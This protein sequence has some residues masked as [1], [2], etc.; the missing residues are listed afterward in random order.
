MMRMAT[1]ALVVLLSGLAISSVAYAEG[2]KP[3]KEAMVE[4]LEELDRR[5][6]SA[7]DFKALL[8][9]E[10]KEKGKNDL[11]YETVVY[12]RDKA[13]KLVILFLKPK[14]EA[15][16]GYL[17]IDKN[18]FMYDPNVGKW[19][20]RTERERIG[21]TTSQRADFD[22]SR[23][24]D[25]FAPSYEG[26]EKLGKLDV[27]HLQLEAKEDADVPYPIV[28]IWIDKKTGNL[29]KRQDHALS[30]KLMRTTYYPKWSK[31][32]NE[33]TGK[34]VYFPKQVRIFDEVEKGKNSTIVFRSVTLK[35]LPDNIFTKAWLESKSR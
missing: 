32:K 10:Q 23:L 29:L 25:E 5:Q 1:M 17:R 21:G 11:V 18:L 34:Y 13:D 22:E 2:D 3:D 8:Y 9:I 20:R 7:G 35:S 16:K 26:S 28:D 27:H 14:S 15:G 19:E 6:S 4:M 24:A 31:I 33:K 30:G 12:R